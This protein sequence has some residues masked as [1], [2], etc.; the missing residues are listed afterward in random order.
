MPDL[1]ATPLLSV[2]LTH[3]SRIQWRLSCRVV[4]V[5]RGRGARRRT[6]KST[7]ATQ[8]VARGLRDALG[9][10][11]TPDEALAYAAKRSTWVA[12]M[13]ANDAPMVESLRVAGY[14]WAR[15]SALFGGAPTSE[16]LRRLYG[17]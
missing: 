11:T 2:N 5:T 4:N 16:T 14:S 6:S 10:R 15:I 7:L 17:P 12:S 13:E 3:I 8:E 1:S 9:V